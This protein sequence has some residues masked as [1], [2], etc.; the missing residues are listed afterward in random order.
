M[1]KIFLFVS[2]IIVF[3]CWLL[4]T[5]CAVIVPPDG[6]PRDT[7]PPVLL[8]AM[9]KDSTLNFKAKTITLNFDEYVT[10]DNIFTNLIVSPIPKSIPTVESNLRTVTIKIKDTLEPNTTYAYDFGKALKDINEGNTLKNFTY[11]FSTGDHLDT[12]SITG[13]VILAQTGGVDS[14]LLAVLYTNLSDSSV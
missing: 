10:L 5:G 1:K 7:L 14:T 12:D 9:P 11:V 13:K 8:Q 3:C 2:I 4:P 6:G